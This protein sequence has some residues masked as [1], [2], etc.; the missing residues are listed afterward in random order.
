MTMETNMTMRK[1]QAFE[2]LESMYHM[3]LLLKISSDFPLPA[4]LV[5]FREV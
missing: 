1:K 3:Y 4:M 5:G 2:S